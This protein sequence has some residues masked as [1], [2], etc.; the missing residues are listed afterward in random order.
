[1]LKLK[2][3]KRQAVATMIA[4]LAIVTGACGS[5]T[6]D[7]PPA[8]PKI[9]EET[10]TAT[11]SW[12][13]VN[14]WIQDPSVTNQ[15]SK[16]EVAFSIVRGIS[17]SLSAPQIFRIN[18]TDKTTRWP[19]KTSN[20]LSDS[21]SGYLVRDLEAASN[22]CA[23]NHGVDCSFVSLSYQP[24]Q[25]ADC[26]HHQVTELTGIEAT[27]GIVTSV[28][29]YWANA[30]KSANEIVEVAVDEYV[31]RGGQ[32]D[33][34]VGIKSEIQPN[35]S[36]IEEVDRLSANLITTQEFDGATTEETLVNPEEFFSILDQ[37]LFA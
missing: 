2:S 35:S 7:E 25:S 14:F 19:D 20:G 4:G 16:Q 26:N 3:H 9:I 24:C 8:T 15:L 18:P 33:D 17:A 34:A 13:W 12:M 29:L 1:M 28:S 27:N 11:N 31:A 30:T 36:Q 6:Q 5:Q 37:L 10:E 22:M 32:I 21:L 23:S